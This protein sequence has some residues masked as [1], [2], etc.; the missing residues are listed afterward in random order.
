MSQMPNSRRTFSSSWVLSVLTLQGPHMHAHLPLY[1]ICP[2]VPFQQCQGNHHQEFMATSS[3][4]IAHKTFK[5]VLGFM[6]IV[7]VMR[8]SHIGARCYQS[9]EHVLEPG[10]VTVLHPE[11][12]HG[13]KTSLQRSCLAD[14]LV[15]WQAVM[16]WRNI[17]VIS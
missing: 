10:A 5:V 11:T 1:F 17:A 12:V 15:T 3:I 16:P 7:N 8:Q 6:V 9:V 14:S 4:T 2:I 13:E